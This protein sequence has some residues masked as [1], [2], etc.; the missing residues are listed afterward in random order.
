M[1]QY[2]Q[3]GFE[4]KHGFIPPFFK[5]SQISNSS[6]TD[7]NEQNNQQQYIT[8]FEQKWFGSSS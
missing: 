2:E 8:A 7:I 1:T 3:K 4:V 6:C 5:S